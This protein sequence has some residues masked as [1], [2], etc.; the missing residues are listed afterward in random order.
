M[1]WTDNNRDRVSTRTDAMLEQKSWTH[2]GMG[3]V[4]TQKYRKSR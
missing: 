4:L 3:N 2:D 1:T